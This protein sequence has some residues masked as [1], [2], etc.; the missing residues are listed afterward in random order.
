MGQGE[1]FGVNHDINAPGQQIGQRW[2]AAAIGHMRQF[3]PAGSTP[4]HHGDQMRCRTIAGCRIGKLPRARLGQRNQIRHI[5][6]RD[7]GI[8]EENEGKIGDQADRREIAPRIIANIGV[9][10]GVGGQRRGRAQQQGMAIGRGLRGLRCGEAP[11][12]AWAVVNQHGPAGIFREPFG[13]QA[14]NHIRCLAGR[15]AHQNADRPIGP[16]LC[17]RCG[18][19][20]CK[21][22]QQC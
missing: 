1:K 20:Y 21:C 22:Q 7:I 14:G 16:F 19:R 4:E 15:K 9:K 8:D 11:A 10:I 18:Q 17:L 12:L 2:R 13:E 5:A 3:K 6:R